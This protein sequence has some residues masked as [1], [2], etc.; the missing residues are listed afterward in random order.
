VPYWAAFVEGAYEGPILRD[1]D[2]DTESGR[3]GTT[4][5]GGLDY[6]FVFTEVVR[7]LCEEVHPTWDRTTVEQRT[8]AHE[9]G[10]HFD[11]PDEM[12]PGG[13]MY[14]SPNPALMGSSFTE[15]NRLA[16]RTIHYP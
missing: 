15:E 10:H 2:P 9:I 7:D 1:A 3:A 12:T 13:L 8:T 6:S 4:I 5:Q 11:L 14:E 16:I